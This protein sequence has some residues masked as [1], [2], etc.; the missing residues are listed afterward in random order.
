M[1]T[2]PSSSK[3]GTTH[4]DSGS[5]SPRLARVDIKQNVDNVNDII[6]MFDIDSPTNT[7]ILKYNSSTTKFEL[8]T[9]SASGG[10]TFVGDDSTGTLVN[11]DESFKVAG[12]GTITTAVSGDV[13][14]ITGS[15]HTI[16]ALN[17]QSANRLVSI[18][19]TTTQLDGEANLTFDGT[20]L[21]VAGTGKLYLNDAGGEHI[22]GSGS[23]LSIAGGSEIDLTAT[24][25][26]I[27]GTCDISSNLA[28]GGTITTSGDASDISTD[29]ISI[30]SGSATISGLRSNEDLNL[31]ANGT[32]LIVISAN[33]GTFSNW[34]TQSRYNG[35][36]NMYY[37]DLTHTIANDRRYTN[38]LTTKIKLDSGQRTNNS[39][40]RWRNCSMIELD[41]N[42]SA[43]NATSSYLS[44]GPIGLSSNVDVKNSSANDSEIGNASGVQAGL[45]VS[46]DSTGDI[47]FIGMN[48]DSST[49]DAGTAAYTSWMDINPNSGSTISIPNVFHYYASGTAA[50]GSG[51]T[52]ITN[53]YAF[54]ANTNAGSSS[55]TNEYAFYAEDADALSAVGKLESYR[56]KINAL[57]S[58]ATITVDCS[59]A[60][61]HTVTLAHNTEYNNTNL[62]AGQT[63]TIKIIQD[64][65]GSRTGTFGTEGSSAVKFAG[66][67]PTLTTTAAGIDIVTIFNDSTD[68]LGNIAK[69]FA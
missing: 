14:T 38:N 32:G 12:A 59:L 45:Q 50:F 54:Y 49:T 27:N 40:D 21:L 46:T 48:P 34:S 24:A 44:R 13:L 7:Q 52:A 28:V 61:V 6:D 64:G 2:W 31:Q 20:D 10:I 5:D 56:E 63:V 11:I 65:T 39:N 60:P 17:N 25:I 41:L 47:S 23:V 67:T 68:Y 33:S 22:S 66:G 69:A 62:G 16:T 43:I 35:S 4:L 51:T 15:A 3:A 9:D 58:S 36:N 42:G 8:A 1:A 26:D 19:S 55:I 30:D 37:E 53:C 57:T 29:T 18:G